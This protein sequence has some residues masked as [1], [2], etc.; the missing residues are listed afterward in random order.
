MGRIEQGDVTEFNQQQTFWVRKGLHKEFLPS[1]EGRNF[2]RFVIIRRANLTI[3]NL[4]LPHALHASTIIVSVLL[5]P[6]V[7]AFEFFLNP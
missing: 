7:R 3:K 2:V 1:S 6:S 4:K 5:Q